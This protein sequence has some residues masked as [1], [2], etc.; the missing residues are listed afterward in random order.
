PCDR[1]LLGVAEVEVVGYPERLSA[2]AREV[3]R[4]LQ[5]RLERPHVRVR[6]HA[7]AVAVDA[8]RERAAVGEREHSGVSLLGSAHGARLHDRVVLLEQRPARGEI[9]AA[10]ERQQRLGGRGPG[11]ERGGRRRGR[12]AAWLAG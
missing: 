6:R 5:Y 1:T 3:R 4:A 7:A 9:G 10:Q 11:G 8:D 12:R 2:G